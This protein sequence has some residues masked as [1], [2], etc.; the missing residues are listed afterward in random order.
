MRNSG[1][2]LA[3]FQV[4]AVVLLYPVSHVL[5][6]LVDVPLSTAQRSHHR[7]AFYY[8]SYAHINST[9]FCILL[10]LGRF[11][12]YHFQFVVVGL[13]ENRGLGF[14]PFSFSMPTSYLRKLCKNKCCACVVTFPPAFLR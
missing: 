12:H 13:H 2:V 4:D 9:L 7:I 8:Q 1:I 11:D 10:G 6:N 3:R 14:P 5:S